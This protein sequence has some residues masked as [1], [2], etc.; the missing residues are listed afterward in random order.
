[1]SGRELLDAGLALLHGAGVGGR[2]EQPRP[3][4]RLPLSGARLVEALEQGSLAHHVEIGRV[5]VI[6][7]GEV[8]A[9]IGEIVPAAKEPPGAPLVQG[10]EHLGPLLGA[11]DARVN[12]RQR[13]IAGEE[14]EARHKTAPG[15]AL[16]DDQPQD[17]RAAEKRHRAQVG[18][19]RPA[20]IEGDQRLFFPFHPNLVRFLRPHGFTF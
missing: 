20:A 7:G 12:D 11:Q 2:G 3:Q 13:H 14:H 8:L 10:E 6:I 19:S 5:E 15:E 16:E 4:R 1:M 17:R 9:L 18:D